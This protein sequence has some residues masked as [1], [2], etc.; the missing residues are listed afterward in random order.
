MIEKEQLDQFVRDLCA[1]LEQYQSLGVK[2]IQIK[3][4]ENYLLG[5]IEEETGGDAI[6]LWSEE[7]EITVVYSQSHWHINDYLN[8]GKTRFMFDLIEQDVFEI[9][10]GK[11]LTYSAWQGEQAL[12][13]G[14]VEG[15]VDDAVRSGIRSFPGA[16]EIH[17]KQWGK[18]L[19]V[20]TVDS[21]TG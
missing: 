3:E 8:T 21:G 20:Y 10:D 7:D 4:T 1:F 9:I 12:G 6:E 11:R 13:S 19:F 14:D 5:K 18:D 16:T 15:T 2:G 17:V